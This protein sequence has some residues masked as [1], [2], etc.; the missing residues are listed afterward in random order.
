M[1][2]EVL[3]DQDN[4]IY[5]NM[6]DVFIDQSLD[7]LSDIV[8]KL[9][10]KNKITINDIITTYDI[11]EK[12]INYNKINEYI[13]N[14]VIRENI[15]NIIRDYVILY[16]LLS[17]SFINNIQYI[18][19][20]IME[21]SKSKK[22][23]LLFK[24]LENK[25]NISLI[26]KYSNMIIN[27]IE[28]L[29]N[30][31]DINKVKNIQQKT[32]AINLINSLGYEYVIEHL[33]KNKKNMKHN[34]LKL[35]IFRM[36]Y[37]VRDKINI[38][39]MIEVEELSKAETTYIEIVDS[40]VEELDYSTIEKLFST[41]IIDKKDV[42]E[43]MYELYL[44]ANT[45]QDDLRYTT[46]NKIQELYNKNIL[47]PI[48]DE[49]LR[50]HKNS[51]KYDKNITKID[52][53]E[54][55]NKKNN[56]KIRYIV[57]KINKLIDYYNIKKKGNKNAIEE[58]D[59][60]LY[61]S[62]DYR[63]AVII[64]EFEELSIITKMENQGQHTINNNE[65]YSDLLLF[66]TYPY[67]N[68]KDFDKYGFNFKTNH[69]LLSIRY[70][71]FEF[72]NKEKYPQQYVNN[73]QTRVA[74]KDTF[75]NIVGVAIN[76]ISINDKI[77]KLGATA[78]VK[79]QDTIQLTKNGY[80]NTLNV[81]K[82]QIKNETGYN[83]L[84]YW[85]FD[86]FNDKAKISY[87]ENLSSLNSEEYFKFLLSKIYDELV[88]ITYEKIIDTLNSMENPTI[89][90]MKITISYIQDVLIDITK[91]SYYNDIL[92]HMYL[93][94][95][96]L[97]DLPD[98]DINENKIPG[99]T[100]ELIKIPTYVNKDIKKNLILIK[101]KE[102][103]TGEKDEEYNEL[104]ETAYCQHQVSWNI[105]NTY[106]KRDPNKFN[107]ALFEFIKKYVIDNK[108][109]E[110]I[111]KSCHQYVDIKKYIYDSF[112]N[113]IS[114]VA[115]TVSLE[116]NL[117]N[118]PEY[119]K[120]SKAIKNMDKI[121]EKLAYISGI[122]YYIGNS[123]SNKYHRQDVIKNTIDLIL[124][125]MGTYDISNIN[126]RKERV[127]LANKLYGIS[128]EL[129]NYFIFDMDNNLFIYSSKD[130]DKFK[131]YKINNILA[132]MVFLI[133]CELNYGQI[134]QLTYDKLINFDIFDKFS[135]NIFNGLFIRINNGND[136]RPILNYRLLCY[137]IYYF[138]G[139]ILK[140]NYW[141]VDQKIQTKNKSNHINPLL[142][143]IIIHTVI[144][145]INSVLE[146]NTRKNKSYVYDIIST[147]FL[148]KLI[149]I[150][151][152]KNIN[153]KDVIDRLLSISDKK[154]QIVGSKIKIKSKDM[155]K[156]IKLDNYTIINQQHDFG[157]KQL[158]LLPG[159]YFINIFKKE[160]KL[161]E[162]LKD[163]FDAFNK[164]IYINTLEKIYKNYDD[165]GNRLTKTRLINSKIE[166]KLLQKH[167]ENIL[168][169]ELKELNRIE[170]NKK[171][172]DNIN[173]EI[174]RENKIAYDEFK[175]NT[176]LNDICNI[177]DELINKMEKSIG[178]NIN[179]NNANI[180]LK[181]NAYIIDHDYLGYTRS[182]PLIFIED[183]GKLEFKKDE[184][185]FKT[186]VLYYLD[187]TKNI[188]VYY[189]AYELYILGYREMNKEYVRLTGIGKYI[190]IN[191]SIKQKLLLMGHNHIHY[192]FNEKDKIQQ[193]GN[194]IRKRIHNLKNIITDIQ[195]IIYQ[196]KNKVSIT[197]TNELV[198]Q[199]SDKFKELNYYND[200]IK[201]FENW[202]S[203]TE[204][205]YYIPLKK[206]TNLELN[207]NYLNANKMT[208]Y[209]NND[210]V[211]LIYLIQQINLFL[212]INQNNNKL[213]IVICLIINQIFDKF[214]I[215]E[216]IYQ[217]DEVRKYSL[218]LLDNTI[219]IDNYEVFDVANLTDNIPD[220]HATD[221]QKQQIDDQKEDFQ[222][223][224]EGMDIDINIG[225][226]TDDGDEGIDMIRDE[227]TD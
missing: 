78:C 61:S 164:K 192:K 181:K 32:D 16:L 14:V 189:D 21:L 149:N 129:T 146:V 76:P 159:K 170:I 27:I 41:Q 195:S 145:L 187:K 183:D 207:N 194:I 220:D 37:L 123:P 227:E 90:D 7:I 23:E 34:I 72:K 174:Q 101:K 49:F 12:K 158:K 73:I 11:N 1:N 131:R 75:V 43:L 65:F 157:K 88:V 59:T 105:M 54:K 85:I 4:T 17:L 197:G 5:I 121:V 171:N 100:T 77:R 40:T 116:A 134:M 57:T 19:E 223:T 167:A 50:F 89:Y 38:F 199:Y 163:K 112:S 202:K 86:K 133:I 166:E 226:D 29:D 66:R 225:D 205:I 175:K 81:L 107:Q 6:I 139:L 2:E 56:T 173:K 15:K 119:E 219:Y 193:L 47:I 91:T 55:T 206:N 130:V 137:L 152:D 92:N 39:K 214:N 24:F 53:M 178:K 13:D 67:I 132:Y 209:N 212:Q 79:L 118:I 22:N 185:Y 196:I 104:I 198:K 135:V 71:N 93:N 108:D 155:T 142:H 30:I 141:Y 84:F 208:K 46:E 83:K 211:I 42:A 99:L 182:E 113:T 221:E 117:E 215:D 70:C 58:V 115:L 25:N 140:Y 184:K 169:I 51:E 52:P 203:I 48:T 186:D 103:L 111:C 201:I 156:M 69:T 204:D 63:K 94:K 98:Y 160:T 150:Y 143:K 28:I 222:E 125:Q 153:T 8:S 172:N 191:Y 60:I 35:I 161:S 44:S 97:I 120:Y 62:M 31:D 176:D 109:K 210:I 138:S 96:I 144:D 147:K 216:L 9:L 190:K 177:I 213:I 136:L 64:N 110:Y 124:V 33:I 128:G 68:F 162:I 114:N 148:N 95:G 106:K 18:R 36:I 87:Y 126:M 168:N 218:L 80:L 165:D 45:S 151:D 179:I 74:S 20:I 188:T 10:N 3:N 224:E 26:I 122:Q 82:N 180:Y 200:G 217:N 154:I 102:F 127:A